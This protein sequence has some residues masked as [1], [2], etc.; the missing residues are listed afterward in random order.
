VIRQ[1]LTINIVHIAPSI[2]KKKVIQVSSF[3]FFQACANVGTPPM[4]STD[5]V[6]ITAIAGELNTCHRIIPTTAPKKQNTSKGSN[7]LSLLFQPRITTER[8]ASAEESIKSEVKYCRSVNE[9][10]AAIDVRIV[11]IIQDTILGLVVF[12]TT[13]I[14]YGIVHETV[15]KPLN[16]ASMV[17]IIRL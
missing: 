9:A 14:I 10:I 6:A 16:I 12:F 11:Q 5:I 1:S 13:S 8:V 15:S 3:G 4:K 7:V 17:T 2:D